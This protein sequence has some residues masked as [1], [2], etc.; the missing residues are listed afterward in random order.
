MQTLSRLMKRFLAMPRLS[1]YIMAFVLIGG[2]M[3]VG[4][5]GRAAFADRAQGDLA[6]KDLGD[7]VACASPDGSVNFW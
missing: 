1:L 6:L 5:L 4:G 2:G 7:I 3:L